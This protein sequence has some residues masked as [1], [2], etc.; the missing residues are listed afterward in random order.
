MKRV[1]ALT[2]VLSLIVVGLTFAGTRVPNKKAVVVGPP[3]QGTVAYDP[4][5]PQDFFRTYDGTN[6]SVGNVFNTRNGNPLLP[7]PLSFVTVYPIAVGGDVIVSVFGAPVGSNAPL[8]QFV[9][10]TGV[11]SNTFNAVPVSPSV[12]SSFLAGQ[13]LGTFGSGPDSI[14][15][16]SASFNGMGFHA[17]QINFAGATSGT[18]FQT[19]QGQNAMVRAS[20]V[21]VPVELMNFKVE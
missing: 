9:T 4:G 16:R 18:G 17:M 7:G 19:I 21:V 8:L 13:Y 11:A 5:P 15:I 10:G 1:V 12:G 2:A 14:G 3:S 20:G 6:R